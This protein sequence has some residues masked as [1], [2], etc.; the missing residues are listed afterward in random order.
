MLSRVISEM[1]FC[2][3]DAEASAEFFET[4][5]EQSSFDM[6]SSC[7][8]LE[9]TLTDILDTILDKAMAREIIYGEYD[10]RK[11][12]LDVPTVLASLR[13]RTS[14]RFP[15]AVVPTPFPRLSIDRQLLR[16]I[17]RN[18]ISNA[19]KY[20]KAEGLV[21]ECSKAQRM[22]CIRSFCV[23]VTNP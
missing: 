7:D 16:Y 18:A 13:R 23:T 12:M 1:S 2:S 5:A 17:Y 4:S 6:K 19:C 20:G 3:Q 9:S 14:R 15:L 8:E 22:L 11:E 21:G 10:P